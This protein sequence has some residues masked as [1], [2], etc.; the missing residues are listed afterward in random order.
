MKIYLGDNQFPRTLKHAI[1]AVFLLAGGS[2]SVT[3]IVAQSIPPPVLTLTLTNS[4]QMLISITNGVSYA[5]YDLYTTPIL[6]NPSYPW[7]AVTIGTNYQTNFIVPI[8]PY[9]AGFYRVLV[10]TNSVPIWAAADPNNPGSGYLS[11]FIDSPTN[12][13]VLQ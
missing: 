10:D 1:I 13:A 3:K 9:S 6:A 4:N 7:T 8:G 2:L 11:V 5:V 12:G